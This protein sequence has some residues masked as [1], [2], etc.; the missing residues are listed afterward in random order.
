MLCILPIFR[1]I[2]ARTWAAT[3]VA[4]PDAA[5][6]E[7][8]PL[9]LDPEL[10]AGSSEPQGD[11]DSE[12]QGNVDS[13]P[14][15]S[16]ERKSEEALAQEELVIA[17]GGLV[18]DAVGMILTWLSRSTAEASLC[19]PPFL[20]AFYSLAHMSRQRRSSARS[21]PPQARPCRR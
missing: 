14:L 15:S 6:H 9:L 19:K 21:V 12:P 4:A 1:A 10:P 7:R 11:V 13:E 17:R 16:R 5:A 18:L 20:L 3:D 8:T 2:Y